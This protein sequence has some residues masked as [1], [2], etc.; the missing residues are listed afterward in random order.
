[1]TSFFKSSPY[2]KTPITNG[3]LDVLNFIDIPVSSDDVLYQV[4]S[5]YEFRPD[6]LAYDLYGDSR[7]WWVFAARNKDILKDSIF[8]LVAGTSIVIPAAETIKKTLGL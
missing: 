7:L 6:L 3:Y 8:D 5:R 2:S 4:N 1:M